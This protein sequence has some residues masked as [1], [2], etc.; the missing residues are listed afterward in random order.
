MRNARNRRPRLDPSTSSSD[1]STSFATVGIAAVAGVL[2]L[3]GGRTGEGVVAIVVALVALLASDAIA[4][5][6]IVISKEQEQRHLWPCVREART[7]EELNAAGLFAYLRDAD[8]NS[9]TWSEIG[10]V[11]AMRAEA[12]RLSDALYSDPQDYLTRR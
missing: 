2:L 4:K 11:S 10:A 1:A 5:E 9:P 8:F 12:E 3:T 7:V 6:A